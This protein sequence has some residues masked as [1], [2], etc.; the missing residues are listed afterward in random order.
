[1]GMTHY[2]AR[3]TEIPANRFATAVADIRKAMEV[4]GVSLGGFDGL[5]TP[6]FKDDTV[7]FNGTTGTAVE[8]FEIHQTEFDRRGRST[9]RSYCKTELA[10]YDL[11]VRIALIILRHHLGDLIEV[12]SDDRKDNWSTAR[13]WTSH[14][15]GYGNDFALLAGD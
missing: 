6:T 7:L 5:G 10:P 13:I 9:V 1:M 15:F 3:P 12:T 2:W 4:A 11:C 14:I 8:P